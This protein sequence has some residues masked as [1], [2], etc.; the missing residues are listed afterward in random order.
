MNVTFISP[1]FDNVK[2][3]H[4]SK[5]KGVR[6]G[7]WAPF[8]VAILSSVVKKMG[9]NFKFID[10][11]ALGYSNEEIL[12]ELQET[13][14]DLIGISAMLATRNEVKDLVRDIREKV[15]LKSPIF[16]GGLIVTTFGERVMEEM[17]EIDYA[18][19]GEAEE[20]IQ[21]LLTKVE[22]NLPVEDV[23]GIFYRKGS[24]IVRTA[25]RPMIKDLDSLPSPDWSI[26]DLNLYRPIPFQ[27]KK[28]PIIP[29][30][31]SRGCGYGL[32]TF[33][34]ESAAFAPKFRRHSPARV[35]KDIKEAVEKF[36][37]K[38]VAFWDDI[39]LM[40]ERWVLEFC[41]LWHEN[42]LDI[43]WSCLGYAESMTKKMVDAVAKAGCWGVY[44][45]FESA[46]QEVLDKVKKGLTI[47]QITDSIQWLHEANLDIRGSFILSLPGETP[48]TA[49]NSVKFAI[50]N[51]LTYVLFLPYFPEYGTPLYNELVGHRSSVDEY[52]GR[53]NAQWVPPGYKDETEVMKVIQTAYKK[54]YF[55]PAYIWKHVK[56]I[57]NFEAIKQY[58]EAVRFVMGLSA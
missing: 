35:I 44:L 46:N 47:K 9:H 36:G 8:G 51:D 37:I 29:Y 21:E 52:K 50:E 1:P 20:T 3:G 17:V 18:V 14:P 26:F 55:R 43:P 38:E 19:V 22:K 11:P 12:K 4:G 15:K 48:K 23:R 34:F 16:L 41:E 42:K 49:M 10:A 32:C 45:G 13:K 39:F 53:T 25:E 56:R 31:G 2:Q 28:T 7:F 30:L 6:Y 5:R 54:F 27:Y 40:N 24:S 58:Y 57:R 33:C